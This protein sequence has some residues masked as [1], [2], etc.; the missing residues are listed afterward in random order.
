MGIDVVHV[1]FFEKAA[2]YHFRM[3]IASTPYIRKIDGVNLIATLNDG[4]RHVFMGERTF[5][6]WK[7]GRTYIRDGKLY[8]SGYEVAIDSKGDI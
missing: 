2:G 7:K 1:Y 3:F 4:T 5:D 6:I 8:K